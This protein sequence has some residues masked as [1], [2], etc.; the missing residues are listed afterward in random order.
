LI[1]LASRVT[2]NSIKKLV[3]FSDSHQRRSLRQQCWTPNALLECIID[4]HRP[5]GGAKSVRKGSHDCLLIKSEEELQFC[6]VQFLIKDVPINQLFKI[7]KG[8]WKN[9]STR[10]MDVRVV[11]SYA[12]CIDSNTFAFNPA[13]CDKLRMTWGSCLHP[14]WVA[15][16]TLSTRVAPCR[17]YKIMQTFSKKVSFNQALLINYNVIKQRYDL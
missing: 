2:L 3:P 4:F 8:S 7:G 14:P 12:V 5:W 6:S 15:D 17:T 16:Q 11:P 9:I 10:V 13:K 1:A